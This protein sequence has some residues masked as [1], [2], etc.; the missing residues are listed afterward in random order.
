MIDHEDFLVD[1]SRYSN[2]EGMELGQLV[3][4]IVEL[5]IQKHVIESGGPYNDQKKSQLPTIL[6]LYDKR[7]KILYEELDNR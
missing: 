2:P 7:L 1:F 6:E 4:E 5:S 3:R